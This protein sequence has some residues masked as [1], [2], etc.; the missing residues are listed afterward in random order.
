ML[1]CYLLIDEQ[2]WRREGGVEEVP[3]NDL[4]WICRVESAVPILVCLWVDDGSS[5]LNY[6]V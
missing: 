3:W 2:K 6:V 1:S 4:V 5:G